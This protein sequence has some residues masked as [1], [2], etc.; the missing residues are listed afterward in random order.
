M[1]GQQQQQAGTPLATGSQRVDVLGAKA[2]AAGV[3]KATA[4]KVERVKKEKPE[5]L[6]DI[7]A[8]KT[9]ANKVI[10]T[11]PKNKN[12]K[13]PQGKQK[14][15]KL[16]TPISVPAK[17]TIIDDVA[18][19][20]FDGDSSLTITEKSGNKVQIRAKNLTKQIEA[21]LKIYRRSK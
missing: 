8:G 12:K 1:K 17:T 4:K 13:K 9:T 6:A 15:P 18:G 19:V 20:W 16:P 5:A 3:S 14:K 21:A 10:K 11:L 7:A 2:K